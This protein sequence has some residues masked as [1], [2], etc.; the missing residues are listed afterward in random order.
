MAFTVVFGLG[1]RLR[2]VSRWT[3]SNILRTAARVKEKNHLNRFFTMHFF[4]EKIRAKN[5]DTSHFEKNSHALDPWMP[6][7][8]KKD[9]ETAPPK[10]IFCRKAPTPQENFF[11]FCN[12]MFG[13]FCR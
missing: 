10:K 5:R 11:C 12:F 13:N 8:R 1:L 3:D 6:R 9:R 4:L 7:D 2:R